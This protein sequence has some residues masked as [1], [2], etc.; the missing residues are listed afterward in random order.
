MK[1]TIAAL[2]TILM[3]CC[4][5]AYA[6][7]AATAIPEI[8]FDE[9]TAAYEGVWLNF[10][11]D[12]FMLYLPADWI[13][14]EITDEMLATGTYYVATSADGAYAMT[15]TYTAEAQ[16]TTNEEI[17]AQLTEAG[18]ENVTQMTINGI[19]VVGYIITA[20]DVSGMAFA[21]G[22]GGMYVISFVPASDEAFAPI[23]Q[24]M[25]SSLSPIAAE[26]AE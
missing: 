19:A 20:Q 21:D 1:R 3:L 13:D 11:D 16:V 5:S 6:E 17:V 10:E 4:V 26:A 18:Y 22:E 7:T 8:T 25:M 14:A 15:V 23:G 9:T 12:G 2:M 24:T